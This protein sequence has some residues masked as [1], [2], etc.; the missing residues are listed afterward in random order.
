MSNELVADLI[1]DSADLIEKH[2]W[3]QRTDHDDHGRFCMAGALRRVA[4]EQ[5]YYNRR[6]Y[7]FDRARSALLVHMK[8]EMP[9][10]MC[11][12]AWNDA[13]FRMKQQV[14]DLMRLVA[15]EQRE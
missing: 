9:R 5:P 14:L 6:D 7:V 11:I 2:D 4:I 13:P 12:E 15:K 1:D 3:C 8:L 10:I